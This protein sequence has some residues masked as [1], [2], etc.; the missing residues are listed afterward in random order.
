MRVIKALVAFMGI[1]IVVGIGL[2]V[3]GLSLD[4]N[5][6]DTVAETNEPTVTPSVPVAGTNSNTP[7]AALGAFGDI[8]IDMDDD[9]RLVGFTVDGNRATLHIEGHHGESARLVIVSLTEKKVLG[10]IILNQDAK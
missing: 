8:T 3:Y 5:N 6:P 9:E 10:R 2:V 7:Q 1:L 4:K